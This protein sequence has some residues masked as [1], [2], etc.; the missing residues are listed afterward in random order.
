MS[1]RNNKPYQIFVK[2]SSDYYHAFVTIEA[3][4]FNF[5]IAKEEII[6]ALNDRKVIFGIKQNVID[7]IVENPDKVNS[8]EV[9][10]GIEHE[11]GSNASIVYDVD[12]ANDLKPTQ[13]EDGKVDFKDTNFVQSVK[14]G[15][16]LA[17]MI[18]STEG[19]PGTT[20]TGMSIRAKDGKPANFKYGSNV[21]LAEDGLSITADCDGT[22]KK[23]GDKISVIEVLEV[24]SDVGVKTGNIQFSGRIVIKGNVTN[25]YEVVSGDT[26]EITGVVESAT[27]KADGDII[28]NGGVQGNDDC[29]IEA[30]GEVKANYFNNCKV[31]AGGNITADSLMHCDATSDESIIVQGKKGLL[32]GG[33]YAAR[34]AIVAQTIGTD[35]GT[36]TKLQLGLTNEIMVNFQTLA[37]DIKDYK[38]NVSKLKK[39]LD[40][41]KKQKKAKPD[42]LKISTM[43][44]TTCASYEDY[45]TKL[46]SALIDFKDIN[47]LIE[48]LKDVYVKANT[49][50]PGVRVRIGNSH[51]SVKSA[52]YQAKI[53]K[54]HG[55]IVMESF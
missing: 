35:I 45:N 3:D 55:E 31:I 41:L 50:Y 54:D 30:K 9:A 52:T 19:K 7:F 49:V 28:I 32:L 25:G 44:E 12:L 20:V 23:N 13:K 10:T 14:K 43:Y 8:L 17:H 46:S 42:D 48:R 39:A 4:D 24:F 18:P 26:I 34:H 11:H 1:E 2:L 40:I 21:T 38:G 15:V 37:A 6:K 16:V 27:L 51:Y 22:I 29:L 36:I 53:V 33:E 5:R 47:E